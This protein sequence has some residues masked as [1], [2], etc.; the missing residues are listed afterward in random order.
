L[1]WKT[2]K[3]TW[4]LPERA[5]SQQT[6]RLIKHGTRRYFFAAAFAKKNFRLVLPFIKT[7]KQFSYSAVYLSTKRT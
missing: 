1:Y 5:R 3:E 4:L 6:L 2:G 7:F